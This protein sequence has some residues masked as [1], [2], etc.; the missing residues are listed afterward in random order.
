MR[1]ATALGQ[2]GST[3]VGVVRGDRV[4]LVGGALPGLGDMRSIAGGG[5]AAR[6][7]LEAWADGLAAGEWL[8]LEAVRLGP[9]VTDPG[10]IFT[11]G[12]NYRPGPGPD[13]GGA[14]ERP[15]VYGKLPTS[16]AGDGELLSWD[17]SLTP[18]VDPEVELGIVI[19]QAVEGPVARGDALRHVF[20]WTCIN[21]VS[22]RDEWLD[23]DQWLLGKS[24]AGF[25]PVG[26]WIV[27]PDELDATDLHLTAAIN[28]EPIQ[29][30]R[31][32]WMR[33]DVAA[34]VAFLSRHTV[35]RPGDL[36][37]SGTPPRLATPPG[38]DRHL[39]PGD[40]VTIR[41]EGIG[42]LVTHVT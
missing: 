30:G 1:L 27:T 15:L 23:G 26:P 20:G 42:T 38:P 10:A 21:D 34:I 39:E 13:P 19:G 40:V 4:A 36:I 32:S 3:T 6:R 16:V 29:D 11:I 31:T 18:N 2:D 5:R 8:P 41:I 37:A 12:Q 9:V 14:L 28:G 7:G 22:S 25:C 17:R 33:F 24:M 35:L